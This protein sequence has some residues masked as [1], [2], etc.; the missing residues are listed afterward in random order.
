MEQMIG[1]LT[2]EMKQHSTPY[3]N[4]SQRA[5]EHAEVNAL[6]AMLPELDRDTLK[7]G[8]IPRGGQNLGD[9]YILLC[10]KDSCARELNQAEANALT[11]YLHHD[12]ACGQDC[13]PANWK[14]SAVKWA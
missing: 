2:E 6:K 3:A 7:E 5:V 9:D 13:I 14:A 4:L 11:A 10:A 8:H 1:N 12:S